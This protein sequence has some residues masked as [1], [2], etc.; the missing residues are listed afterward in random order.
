MAEVFEHMQVSITVWLGTHL[1]TASERQR[2][3]NRKWKHICLEAKLPDMLALAN[4]V[5][6]VLPMKLL[7]G[8]IETLTSYGWDQHQ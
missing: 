2:E 7:S 5:H 6:F 8:K 3:N 4:L 1:E